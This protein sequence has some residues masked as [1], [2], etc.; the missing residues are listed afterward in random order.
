MA[1]KGKEVESELHL[2]ITLVDP[3]AGVQFCL[4]CRKDELIGK[5]R[6]TGKELS[7]DLSVRAVYAGKGE[8]PR[9]LGPFTQGPPATRFI[10]I[11]CGTSAGDANSCW[12]RRTKI[13]LSG[14]TGELIERIRSAGSGRLEARIKGTARDGGPACATVPLLDGWRIV[15]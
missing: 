15:P 4:Q 9:F 7:F 6:A 14:I 12:T 3:P 11:R 8:V 5:V 1:Q 2:R 13:P 10:Y